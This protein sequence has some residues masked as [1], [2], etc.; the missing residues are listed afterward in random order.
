MTESNVAAVNTTDATIGNAFDS[1]QILA[2][3]FEGRDAAGVL[4]LQP[5]A[6]FIGTNVDDNID[7]RNG[8]HQRRPQ[9]SGQHHPR[10]RR[11]Q[12]PESRGNAFTGAV[13]ST[14]DSIEEFRVT[15]AGDNAD[16][17]R[18]SGGQVAL[19]TKSGTNT[20]PRLTLRTKPPDHHRGQRL[21]QQTRRA[22]QRR[23]K[24]AG[25][26]YSQHLWRR[27]RRPD[28]ERSLIFLRNLRRPAACRRHA[29]HSQRAELEPSRWRG[30]LSLRRCQR[31]PGRLDPGHQRRN[32]F[33]RTGNQRRRPR[34]D[35][36]DGP[37]LPRHRR[38]PERQRRQLRRHQRVQSISAAQLA[39]LP[40]LRRLQLLVLHICR[41][42]STES[43]H[44]DR[45]DRLQHHEVGQPS[46]VPARKLSDRSRLAAAAVPRTAAGQCSPRHQPRSGR[47]LHRGALQHAHQQLS[48]RPDA[49]EPGQSRHRD[50]ADRYL[51]RHRRPSSRRLHNL[52]R[53]LRYHQIP[54]PGAQL[55]GRCHLDARQAH[56]AIR[57]EYSLHQQRPRKRHR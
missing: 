56:T 14:L 36:S 45:Q 11:Q 8:S 24:H 26:N 47:R 12:S 17:G 15:T 44:H 52:T 20:V 23:G 5:G 41:G 53:D 42:Q 16:Q 30:H 43:Q 28:S 21:V 49:P 34:P 2:L 39:H 46:S 32:V 50:G 31:L 33:L 10:R 29:G 35:Q 40:E 27:A 37:G 6:T 9:R 55:G 19:V 25:Q 48:L 57:D 3:P 4:S 13:R 18:S 54:Y 51:P 22:E 1:K 7:T 38:L